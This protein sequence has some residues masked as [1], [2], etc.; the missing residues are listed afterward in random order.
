MAVTGIFIG[1]NEGIRLDFVHDLTGNPAGGD[2]PANA[3]FV[4]AGHYEVNG[5]AVTFGGLNRWAGSGAFHG[6][7]RYRCW[8]NNVVNDGVVDPVTSVAIRFG[9]E[10]KIVVL[11]SFVSPVTVGGRC[12]YDPRPGMMD[13]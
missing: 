12:L 11:A 5:A 10:T 2:F 13:L 9:G 1:T 6:K 7:R 8:G 4:F 3:D